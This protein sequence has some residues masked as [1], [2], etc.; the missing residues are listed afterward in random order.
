MPAEQQTNATT[1]TGWLSLRR[2]P[3]VASP[4][5]SDSETSGYVRVYVLRVLVCLVTAR[6]LLYWSK[7]LFEV[8]NVNTGARECKPR[9]PAR[10]APERIDEPPG[11]VESETSH[12][13]H[14]G[15]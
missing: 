9:Q 2:V 13:S 3:L 14:V 10:L 6:G 1:L 12:A 8:T 15:I 7:P 5:C 4:S 11:P